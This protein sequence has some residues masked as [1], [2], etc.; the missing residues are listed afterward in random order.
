MRFPN[1]KFSIRALLA[2]IAISACVVA[3]AV[4]YGRHLVWAL[5]HYGSP[6]HSAFVE[7][8]ISSEPLGGDF[9]HC[10]FREISFDLPSAIAK[11]IT[12][13]TDGPAR[14]LEFSDGDKKVRVVL[15]SASANKAIFGVLPEQIN[16][17]STTQLLR[18]IYSSD[19][20]DFSL[21]MPPAQ[22][23]LHEWA[24]NHRDV[25]AY[26][27][28]LSQMSFDDGNGI[29]VLTLS[30][31]PK[32]TSRSSKLKRLISWSAK[33]G[34]IGGLIY[35]FDN[36]DATGDWSD[37]IATSLRLHIALPIRKIDFGTATDSEILAEAQITPMADE[38]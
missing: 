35:I 13:H 27:R 18:R 11:T 5:T 17:E 25:F 1:R 20:E 34:S 23:L 12:I 14:F 10:D 16:G 38:P 7:T 3:F 32:T 28:H 4:S 19:S 2:L 15:S 22:L 36:E 8:T 29:Q 31:D 37:R 26:E 6:R 33:D 9:A 30:S 21:N 24:I